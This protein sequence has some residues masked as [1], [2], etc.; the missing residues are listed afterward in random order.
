MRP[1]PPFAYVSVLPLVRVAVPPFLT[2]GPLSVFLFDM[3]AF[4]LATW[5]LPLGAESRPPLF[6]ASFIA[7]TGARAEPRRA[8]FALRPIFAGL[9]QAPRFPGSRTLVVFMR[10]RGLLTRYADH[11]CGLGGRGLL[12][13]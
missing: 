13:A 11:V 10:V 5:L 3:S 7:H 9:A 12:V 6:N 1:L 2:K 8:S 4:C